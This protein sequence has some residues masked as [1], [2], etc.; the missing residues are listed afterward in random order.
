MGVIILK[1]EAFPWLPVVVGV[2]SIL[3]GAVAF[4]TK[5]LDPS[6][7]WLLVIVGAICVTIG[8]RGMASRVELHEDKIVQE[9]V[10]LTTK[11]NETRL[12]DVTKVTIVEEYDDGGTVQLWLFYHGKDL[13]KS[14]RPAAVWLDHK[15]EI[16]AYLRKRG[17]EV[18]GA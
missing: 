12:T 18:E 17:I 9:V 15:S 11:R 14:F 13:A 8:L 5:W 4:K 3:I 6:R 10:T 2:L 16:V 1:N 7:R